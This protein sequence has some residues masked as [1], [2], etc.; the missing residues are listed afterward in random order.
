MIKY[1]VTA[2]ISVIVVLALSVDLKAGV[3]IME[4]GNISYSQEKKYGALIQHLTVKKDDHTVTVSLACNPRT[5]EI[6]VKYQELIGDDYIVGEEIWDNDSLR[7]SLENE[8]VSW[9]KNN[10]ETEAGKT[11]SNMNKTCVLVSLLRS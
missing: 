6:A 11:W 4:T 8:Y 7:N 1:I 10:Q 2:A 3:E 5:N 9:L